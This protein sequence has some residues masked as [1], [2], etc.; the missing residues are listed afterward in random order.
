VT[1][2]S[3]AEVDSSFPRVGEKLTEAEFAA[4]I[5]RD[6]STVSKWITGGVL[7]PG[8]DGQTWLRQILNHLSTQAAGRM[9]A[10]DGRLILD[11]EK[12]LLAHQQTEKII[13]ELRRLRGEFAPFPLVCEA[14]QACHA[15][16]K[17]QLLALPGRLKNMIPEIPARRVDEAKDEIRTI[18]STLSQLRLPPD[19]REHL[20]AWEIEG[21]ESYH[22][23]K[24]TATQKRK[25]HSK[26]TRRKRA[27]ASSKARQ[28]SKTRARKFHARTRQNMGAI[29]PAAT[30]SEKG[31]RQATK[32]QGPEPER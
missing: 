15:L 27:S 4:Y 13:F 5:G 29:P 12:A 32:S 23:G 16:V 17:Q 3:F 11:Q 19:V 25:G 8:A 7:S 20:R 31:D 22:D 24:A 10:T 6:Q 26:R 28:D 9:A 14:L 18:L 1:Q 30:P 2:T 21:K